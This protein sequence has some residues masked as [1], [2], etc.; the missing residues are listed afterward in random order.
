MMSHTKKEM[1]HILYEYYISHLE[2]KTAKKE[3]QEIKSKHQSCLNYNPHT[4]DEPHCWD[5]Q[6]YITEEWCDNCKAV[7]P[8]YKNFIRA[9]LRRAKAKRKV[10]NLARSLT[11]QAEKGNG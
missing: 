7:Q 4:E 1:E 6:E 9:S 11:T 5:S 3:R 2:Y 10:F 8:Y